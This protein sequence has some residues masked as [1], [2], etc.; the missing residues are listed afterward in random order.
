M[1]SQPQLMRAL[2]SMSVPVSQPVPGERRALNAE[3]LEACRLLGLSE[4]QFKQA[5]NQAPPRETPSVT[6]AQLDGDAQAMAAHL[7]GIDPKQ[8]AQYAKDVRP[9]G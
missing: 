5:K 6:E 1:Q 4:D 8:M 7:L 3:E 2:N 9:K